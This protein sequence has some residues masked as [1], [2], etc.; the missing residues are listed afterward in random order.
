METNKILNAD[1]LDITYKPGDPA[2]SSQAAI[3]LAHRSTL[4]V[5]VSVDDTAIGPITRGTPVSL[6]LAALPGVGPPGTLH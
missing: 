6:P 1:V 2:S 4:P 3:T 5:S